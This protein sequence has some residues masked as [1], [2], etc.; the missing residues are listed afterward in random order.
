VKA[1]RAVVAVVID[2]VVGDSW[3]VSLGIVLTLG[4][5]ALLAQTGAPAWWLPPLAVLVLLSATVAA[6]R[7]GHS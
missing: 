5:T 3:R 7:R 6:A 4:A 2:L 1:L